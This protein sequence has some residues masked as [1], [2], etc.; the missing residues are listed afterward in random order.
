MKTTGVKVT[1]L[2]LV[3]SYSCALQAKNVSLGD[4]AV[5]TGQ[6]STAVG[7]GSMALGNN[8]TAEQAQAA[9]K[10]QNALLQNRAQAHEQYTQTQALFDSNSLA[11]SNILERQEAM[12]PLLQQ[13]ETLAGQRTA[14]QQQVT[15]AQQAADRMAQI[16]ERNLGAVSQIVDEN[17]VALWQ[18]GQADRLAQ[19]VKKR[20][21]QDTS[22]SNDTPFYVSYV[23]AYIEAKTRSALVNETIKEKTGSQ[24]KTNYQGVA[25]SPVLSAGNS[26]KAML[27]SDAVTDNDQKQLLSRL[28][29]N[30]AALKGVAGYQEELAKIAL[31]TSADGKKN[32]YQA[33]QKNARQQIEQGL[34]GVT[35]AG[36]QILSE[37]YLDNIDEG[38]FNQMVSDIFTRYE[39]QLNYLIPLDKVNSLSPDSPDYAEELQQLLVLESSPRDN[40][41]GLNTNPDALKQK[42]DQYLQD[43]ALSHTQAMSSQ[44]TQLKQAEYQA[45]DKALN[46][47]QSTLSQGK[48][49][50]AVGDKSLALGEKSVAL[51]VDAW[52]LAKNSVALGDGSLA[53]RD[54]SVS[55]GREGQ[56]RFLTHV[57]AGIAK[58][59]A[60]NK[61]QLDEERDAR[62]AGDKQTLKQAMDYTDVSIQYSEA[63]T[64]KRITEEQQARIEGDEQTLAAA[65]RYTDETFGQVTHTVLDNAR[66]YTD[67][68]FSQLDNKISQVEKRANAG[69]AGVTA[70]SSI[71]YVNSERFSFGMA[72]GHYRDAQAIAT[73]VQYKPT[74]NTNVR[75][76]ASWNN[77]GDTSIGAGFAVGW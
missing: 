1:L 24:I 51:G 36:K 72:M 45:A 73:G 2:A 32:L 14:Q 27:W 50:V 57:A 56:E 33:Y 22:V 23:N 17:F 21:E 77:G 47:A 54:N 5:A 74:A 11:N 59:D 66:Q 15:Q 25:L 13:Q 49:A 48:Q 43:N 71:P 64:N 52:A 69:I 20:V 6:R 55:V 7:E 8:M 75:L 42:V 28:H 4:T 31:I 61:G 16:Y 76:N 34:T 58:T 37:L 12:K 44:A 40:A 26:D 30:T 53:D 41:V 67:Q 18:Q 19:E 65:N 39:N 38:T 68:R 62:I 10:A 9:M 46:E 60:V 35:E 63:K 29:L 70:I 3:V